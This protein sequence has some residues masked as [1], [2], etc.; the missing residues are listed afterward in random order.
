MDVIEQKVIKGK[1]NTMHELKLFYD[2]LKSFGRE[3]ACSSHEALRPS[4][5]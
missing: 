3:L 5:R 2:W 4:K 1:H